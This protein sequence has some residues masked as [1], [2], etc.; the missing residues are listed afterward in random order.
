MQNEKLEKKYSSS[1]K[2]TLDTEQR[3]YAKEVVETVP[4]KIWSIR[5]PLLSILMNSLL[6]VFIE[7]CYSKDGAFIPFGKGLLYNASPVWLLFWMFLNHL[8]TSYALDSGL[9]ILI[10]F[11]MTGRKGYS[12]AIYGFYQANAFEKT[13]Y[14][15]KLSIKSILRKPLTILSYIWVLYLLAIILIPLTTIQMYSYNIYEKGEWV[16][17]TVYIDDDNSYDRGYPTANNQ[18]GV[19]EVLFGTVLGTLRSEEAVDFT[20]FVM[21]PQ[22]MDPVVDSSTIIGAGYSANISTV[23]SCSPGITSSDFE[24][25]GLD[26]A[27]AVL[28]SDSVSSSPA[29][30]LVTY[31]N[32]TEDKIGLSNVLT[33]RKVCGGS[34]S[35]SAIFYPTCY[36]EITDFRHA[37][38]LAAYMTDG[39]PASIS[40]KSSDVVESLEPANMSKL[41]NALNYMYGG[42]ITSQILPS[43][44]P[45]AINPLIWWTTTNTQTI[46]PPLLS[47]GIETLHS[48]LLRS[49]IQRYFSIKG[50]KCESRV[51]SENSVTLRI[52]PSG[53]IFGLIFAGTDI[54]LAVLSIAMTA[55]WLFSKRLISPAV[56]IATNRLYF[57]LMVCSNPTL[58]GG[59]V[60]SFD[61]LD[62]WVKLDL[63]GKVGE[64]KDTIDDE[65]YGKIALNKPKL[66]RPFQTGKLYN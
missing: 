5:Y 14:V 49:S 58:Y 8:V 21:S 20:S 57:Q 43:T 9:S 56:R 52:G 29:F 48:I 17:C 62:F 64:S 39:T 46:S 11:M 15:D 42:K 24:K 6:L 19:A 18:F 13:S 16:S 36:T 41:Y 30:S 45:S 25:W 60:T 2:S 59:F 65:E 63:M 26:T 34:Q 4:F 51:I 3:G 33:V 22:L 12:I 31:L 44:F 7:T 40:I 27:A 35:N 38:V 37:N 66:V 1:R 47:A 53:H 23:C 55:P 61:M 32:R 10:G 54:F 28:L 50:T